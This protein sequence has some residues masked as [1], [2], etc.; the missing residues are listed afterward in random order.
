MRTISQ[1]ERPLFIL[2]LGILVP[3]ALIFFVLLPMRDSG[4]ALSR[5]IASLAARIDQADTMYAELSATQEEINALQT[6]AA[7]LFSPPESDVVPDLLREIATL[8]AS[9][10]LQLR[11]VRPGEPET[12]GPCIRYPI[13]FRVQS[14]LSHIVRLLYE[15]EQPPHRLWVEGVEIGPGPGEGAQ[16]AALLHVATYTLQPPNEERDDE[17]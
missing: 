14:D 10:G 15:L 16:L 3:L 6:E 17:A 9:Q 12:V 13:E 1:R 7:Q 8:T 11:S 5:Q 2:A 4:P